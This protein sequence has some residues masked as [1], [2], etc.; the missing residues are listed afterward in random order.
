[1]RFP[2]VHAAATTPAQRLG[3]FSLISPSRISLPRLGCRVGLRVI[4]FEACSAFT[5]V[6]ACTLAPSPYIV[7][8]IRGLQTFR[9][10]HAC[11]DCFRRELSPGG[12]RTHW[13]APPFTAHTQGG[14]S[15]SET[16]LSVEGEK[17]KLAEGPVKDG[18]PPRGDRQGCAKGGMRTFAQNEHSRRERRNDPA[19]LQAKIS[20]LRCEARPD[21][22]PKLAGIVRG[23]GSGRRAVGERYRLDIGGL[24][25]MALLGRITFR[26]TSRADRRLA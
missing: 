2:C 20:E 4:L 10:L 5:H 21:F 9:R 23:Y 17:L 22:G 25:P 1:M 16:Q 14:Y 13:K 3:V 15:R 24:Q 12:S 8:A 18:R 6:A 11:P 26:T 7:T 19:P